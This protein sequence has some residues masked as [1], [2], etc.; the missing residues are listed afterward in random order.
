MKTSVAC[1]ERTLIWFEKELVSIGL[2][3]LGKRQL[4]QSKKPCV[5]YW[6]LL[7]IR[8]TNSGFKQKREM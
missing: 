6:Y 5:I 4:D 8:N 7:I 1:K 3:K 2:S